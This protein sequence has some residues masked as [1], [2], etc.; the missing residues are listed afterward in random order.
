MAIPT[1]PTSIPNPSTIDGSMYCP[2]V[3][4]EFDNGYVSTRK[5]FTKAREK[6]SSF[7]WKRLTNAEYQILETFFLSVQGGI[8]TW[9]HPITGKTY[10]LGSSVDEL[11]YSILPGGARSVEWALEERN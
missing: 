9:V 5:R 8:F 4:D 3:R 11:K 10:T 7:S 6:I 1:F 2:Q